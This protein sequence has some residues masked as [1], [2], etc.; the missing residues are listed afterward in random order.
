MFGARLPIVQAPMLGASGPEMAREATLAGAIGFL[1]GAG[2]AADALAA[3]I[4]DLRGQV[5]AAPFGVNLFILDPAAPDPASVARAMARLAPYRSELGLAEQAI[6]NR[7]AEDFAEQFETLV[8]AAPPIASFTFGILSPDQCRRL[9]HA[10]TRVIGTATTVA[11]ARAWH[12]VGADA[13]LAQGFEAGGHRG[14]FLAP[15]EDSLV[16]VF[17]LVQAVRAAVPIPVIAGGAIADGRAV[18]AM[19]LLGAA[20]VQMGTAFLLAEESRI[21][22]P[23][24]AALKT[25]DADATRLTR[26]FSGRHARGIENRFMREMDDVDV[27]PYPIQNSL[28]QDLRAANARVGRSDMLS[29]WAGQGVH[30]IREGRTA[31]L[32]REFWAEAR[33][34]LS[35]TATTYSD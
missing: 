30:A 26:A 2:L 12:A 4:A 5:D 31:D 11:E 22:A 18:A 34:A 16:G 24:R 17:A 10:G 15:I 7:W 1:A 27:P 13:V 21:S 6:P 8:A 23:W 9:R 25:S 3:G 35:E 19:L 33:A 20:A 29:L 14:T 28:T 32:I